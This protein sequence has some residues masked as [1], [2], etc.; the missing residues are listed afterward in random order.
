MS[1]IPHPSFTGERRRTTYG[2]DIFSLG[3][4]IERWYRSNNGYE[5]IT[6]TWADFKGTEVPFSHNGATGYITHAYRAFK[7][8]RISLKQVNGTA[9]INFTSIT[10]EGVELLASTLALSDDGEY[11]EASVL[12][13]GDPGNNVPR[14]AEISFFFA[15]PAPPAPGQPATSFVVKFEE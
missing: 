10:V 4:L 7:A 11:H 13:G 1:H 2:W 6:G 3:T 9:P 5:T 14:D 8:G 15:E 12:D